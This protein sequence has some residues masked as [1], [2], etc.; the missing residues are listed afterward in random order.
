MLLCSL[1]LVNALLVLAPLVPASAQTQIVTATPGYINLGMTT[2][3]AVTAPA[4]GT[5]TAVV[6]KPDGSSSSLP[7][8]FTAGGKTQ[9]SVFGNAT[10]G[11]GTLV[12]QV[13]T[14]NV[15]VEQG[16]AVMGTTSFYAT[17]KI[18][19]TMDMVTGGTCYFINSDA[20][21][22][23]F[24][25]RFYASYASTGALLNNLTPGVK[26]TFTQ[27]DGK[28]V[29]TASWDTGALLFRGLVQPAWNY[30]YIGPW[31]PTV[32]AQD[33]FGNAGTYTYAGIPFIMTAATLSTSI[34]MIDVKTSAL[35]ASI[36]PG[37]S[38]TISAT[39]TYP[40]N[41]EPTSG[42]V[43]GLD[44]VVRGGVA[45][46]V[47]GY[48][49]YNATTGTFKGGDLAT[50]KLTNTNG[51]NGTWTGQFVVPASLPTLPAGSSFAV[52][53]T[54]SDKANPSNTGLQVM[55]LGLTTAPQA[56]AASTSTVTSVSTAT[57][58]V[59]QVSTTT[60]TVSQVTQSIPTIAY[61]GMAILLIIGLA[62]GLTVRMPK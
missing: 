30:T 13:G 22:Y 6:I 34:Q 27:P 35:V 23:K 42:F 60:Q 52:S 32:T 56:G 43:T 28:T 15:F 20:R 47:V 39:V 21:G 33:A 55:D 7:Y 10:S 62:I 5:Y 38:V 24:I 26:I 48:G 14:Y 19:I 44:S 57:Q 11:F 9:A 51:A 41:A 25:P 18:V 46:A 54:S 53:V 45:N 50:V 3:I 61:A 17:N 40:T 2:S 4:A 31:N 8:T 58:V 49:A 16:S 36:Y 59:S 29:S 1:A 37:E 12:N